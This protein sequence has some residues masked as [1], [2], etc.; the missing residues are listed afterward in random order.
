MDRLEISILDKSRLIDSSEAPEYLNKF[1]STSPKVGAL[2]VV[3]PPILSIFLVRS[4]DQQMQYNLEYG[5]FKNILHRFIKYE[6]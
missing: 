4:L 5:K 1:N 2:L 6:F 3:P